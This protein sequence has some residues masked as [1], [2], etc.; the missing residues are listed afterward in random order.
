MGGVLEAAVRQAEV[1]RKPLSPDDRICVVKAESVGKFTQ[2]EELFRVQLLKKK[3]Y[4]QEDLPLAFYPADNV[5]AKAPSQEEGVANDVVLDKSLALKAGAIVTQDVV[6][7][8]LGIKGLG[9]EVM[10]HMVPPTKSLVQHEPSPSHPTVPEELV[11]ESPG[12]ADAT[13]GSQPSG[14]EWHLVLLKSVTVPNA[15]VELQVGAASYVVS[16]S[17]DELRPVSKL[18]KTTKAVVLHPTLVNGGTPLSDYDYDLCETSTKQALANHLLAWANMRAQSGVENV[19]VFMLSAEDTFPVILQARATRYFKK[20][21]LVLSPGCGVNDLLS[22]AQRADPREMFKNSDGVL[23]LAMLKH[24]ELT[25]ALVVDKR[26]T[27]NTE[28]NK[29]PRELT[30]LLPSPVLA[31]KNTKTRKSSLVNLSPFWAVLGCPGGN[32]SHNMEL[33]VVTFTEK[34]FDSAAG[35]YPKLPNGSIGSLRVGAP[36]FRNVSSIEKDEVLC[37]PFLE[38]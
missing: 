13:E 4:T 10:A 32:A 7:K 28:K 18:S 37:M 33:E 34:G 26:K 2:L 15:S 8:R 11:D 22:P 38:G 9:E 17:V 25:V 6:F 30:F 3:L 35:Q 16:V 36:I 27:T 14:A 29:E 19:R 20:G 23:H 12:L 24:V 1:R 21:A 31:M 5:P